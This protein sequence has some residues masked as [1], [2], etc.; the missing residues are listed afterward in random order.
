MY[1]ATAL[2]TALSLL[3]GYPGGE[4]FSGSEPASTFFDTNPDAPACAGWVALICLGALVILNTGCA[5]SQGCMPPEDTT[6]PDGGGA[7]GGGD[8]DD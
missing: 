1:T 2:L 3:V 6:E 5:L 4:P 7:P 8:G